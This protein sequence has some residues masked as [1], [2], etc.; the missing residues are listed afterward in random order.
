ML[1]KSCW[2]I[3]A[4]IHAVPAFAFFKPSLQP[5]SHQLAVIV[6]GISVISFLVLFALNGMPDSLRLFAIVDLMG[7]PFLAM[8]AC[9][10]FFGAKV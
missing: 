8:A 7:I 2:A 6:V 10:A 9:Q 5:G 1:V 3:L 4:L